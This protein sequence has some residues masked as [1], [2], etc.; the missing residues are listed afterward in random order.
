MASIYSSSLR[1]QL[2]TTG[3]NA[4]T[5]GEVTNTN[6]GTALEEAIVGFSNIT[7]VGSDV[8]LSLAD[9]NTTQPARALKLNLVGTSGGARVLYIPDVKKLYIINNELADAVTVSVVSSPGTSVVVPAGKSQ[10]V[11]C[12]AFNVE[13]VITNINNLSLSTPLAIASGG[14]GANSA[15]NA[16]TNLSVPAVDGT[17]SSGTWPINVTGTAARVAG[18]AINR[19]LY[20]TSTDNTGFIVAPTLPSTYLQWDGSSFAWAAAGGG[21]TGTVT[22][23]GIS[24][25]NITVSNSPITT[26]GT[27]SISIPQA[28]GTNSSVQ[29]GSFGVGTS[30]SGSTGEIRA[31]SNITAY[32]SSDAK[33]K[34]NVKDIEDATYKVSRIG[35]KTFDWKDEYIRKSG[36][37][38]GYFIQKSDFGVIAQDVKEVFPVA[39]RTRTDGTLAVDYEKLVALAFAAIKE[40]SARIKELESK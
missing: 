15:A 1:L 37:E 21:G 38:D 40:L 36:G 12:D 3:E 2:M 17:G 33:L 5:W 39:V 18:G 20:Q 31:T 27:I 19:I 16:R 13:E 34:E 11:Y 25:T 9:T 22:S 14:T 24:G 23:V 6:L 28:V 29:F 10:F 32:Y 8:T 30:A 35:G 26:S 7:F 4:G